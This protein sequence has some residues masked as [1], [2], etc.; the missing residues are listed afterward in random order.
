[1]ELIETFEVEIDGV[2]WVTEKYGING[3]V[4]SENTFRKEV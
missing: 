1:M 3:V 4:Y 2:I